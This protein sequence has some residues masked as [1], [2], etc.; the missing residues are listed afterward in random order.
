MKGIFKSIYIY[1][2]AYTR[3][4]MSTYS[5]THANTW[6][7]IHIHIRIH[8]SIHT[9]SLAYIRILTR[10]HICIHTYSLAYTR[11]H[12]RT[13]TWVSSLS[14]HTTINTNKHTYI[15]CTHTQTQTAYKHH[16]TYIRCVH[17]DITWHVQCS[18]KYKQKEYIILI[19]MIIICNDVHC[20][21][22]YI[23]RRGYTIQ[24][25]SR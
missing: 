9:Y 10:I 25:S 8:P 24:C 21:L 5:H 20:T 19:L 14:I 18:Q 1:T 3:N 17:I 16:D 13:S 12:M 15:H 23:L 11:L 4:N 2:L 6:V 22:L 7:L